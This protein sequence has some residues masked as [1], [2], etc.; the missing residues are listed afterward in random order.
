MKKIILF[1]LIIPKITFSQLLLRAVICNS[2]HEPLPYTN[3]VLIKKQYGT[4]SNEN[5]EFQVQSLESNDTL[6]ITNVAYIPVLIPLRELHNNDTVYLV[7]NIKQLD[8]VIVKNWVNYKSE[9]NLGYFNASNN[10]E[11]ILNP[12]N[13]IATLIENNSFKDG[14]LKGVF[15]G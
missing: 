6:K 1:L 12:G 3:I 13:Q 2:K 11:F 8:E 5:G 9:T 14:Q 15:F 7:D 10:G 4:I